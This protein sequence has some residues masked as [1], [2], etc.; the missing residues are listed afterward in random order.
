MNSLDWVIVAVFFA[1]MIVIGIISY[2]KTD[3]SNDFFVAGGKLPFW[4][5]GISHHV[6][7]YSG[8]VFV[9]YAALAYTYGFSIYS[10]WAFT[11][12]TATIFGA[13]FIP[14]LWVKLRITKK[15]Q[16]PLEFLSERYNL[17]TQQIMAWSG[18]LLKLFDMAAKWVAIALLLNVFTGLSFVWGIF[19]TGGVSMF[20]ITI[21]GYLAVVITDF[22]QF[23][24]QVIAGVSM[25][26]IVVLK[27]G[28]I[29]SIFGIW[30]Q[31]PPEN[32]QIFNSPFTVWFAIIFLLI[33]FFSYNGGTWNLA[34]R[35]ISARNAKEAKKTS[36]LSG[37]LY[38]VWPLILFFPMWASPL[39]FPNLENP[40]TVY[41]LLTLELL[42]HGLIGLV[43]AS[44]FANTMSMTSSDANT[45]AAVI[46][47]D[48]LPNLSDRFKNLSTKKSL[49]NARIT[50][51]TFILGTVI[52]ALFADNFGGVLGLLINWFAAFVGVISVPM[53]L[54]LLPYF[55][56]CGSRGAIVSM[57]FGTTTFI[58]A[59]L[60]IN[61]SLIEVYPILKTIEIGSPIIITLIVYMLFSQI[62]KRYA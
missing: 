41:G 4:L 61:A 18:V 25:F 6:S 20:Y 59:K 54:G 49:V 26:V 2:F 48:I 60:T 42:P 32:S 55:K 34:T 28:G 17:P 29:S 11:V 37:I 43:L 22:V 15:I 16:S 12:G 51:F 40:E 38:L 44:M 53:I 57:F 31:L 36:I 58:V 52:L 39:L 3:D 23:I 9:A 19:L 13:F 47:R 5:L 56:D 7:G 10:W 30:E 1:I 14:K 27:L 62:A 50:T 24:I 8:A 45:I 35:F 21:G 46:N 33:N